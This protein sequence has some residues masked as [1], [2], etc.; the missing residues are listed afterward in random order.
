MLNT[1]DKAFGGFGLTDDTVPHL[2][3][4]DPVYDRQ[5]K[6]WLKLYIP[7]RSAVVLWK[8]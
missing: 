6:D 4:Y 3:N 2:T 5:D 8:N 7:A 1:D